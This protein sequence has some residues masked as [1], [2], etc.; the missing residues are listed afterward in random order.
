MNREKPRRQIERPVAIAVEG[1]DYFYTLLSRIKDDPAFA[2]VQLW[3]FSEPP[4]DTARQWISFLRTL[5]GYDERVKAIGLIRDA[6]ASAEKSRAELRTAFAGNGLPIPIEPMTVAGG[7]PATG[8][9]VMPHGRETGCLE[10]A[11]LEAT[12]PN[13]PVVCAGEF[14]SCVN[15][16]VKNENWRAKVRVHAMIAAGEN[17]AMTL[18]Q[19]ISGGE[20]WNFAHPSLAVMSDFIAALVH[21]AEPAT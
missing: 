10:H 2:T 19:S 9:L 8:F 18:G 1:S 5:R 4:N 7:R 16:P 11:M 21:A 12:R 14:L 20:L 6:E 17:P 15:R 3:N 13:A